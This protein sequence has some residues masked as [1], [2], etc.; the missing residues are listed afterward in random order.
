MSETVSFPVDQVNDAFDKD[1]FNLRLGVESPSLPGFMN[2]DSHYESADAEGGTIPALF[3]IT[4]I[5]DKKLFAAD[6]FEAADDNFY[7][8]R[9]FYPSQVTVTFH[10][11]FKRQRTVV[12]D[13]YEKA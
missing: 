2:L 13:Y 8:S 3:L 12:Q 7:S 1:L 6:Y 4:R 10:E 9:P 5:S 11:V